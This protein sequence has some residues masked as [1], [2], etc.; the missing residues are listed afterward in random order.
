MEIFPQHLVSAKR[1]W[2]PTHCVTF[3]M[4]PIAL[5]VLQQHHYHHSCSRWLFLWL[6][7]PFLHK[8]DTHGMYVHTIKQPI[9]LSPTQDQTGRSHLLSY[10]MTTHTH[11][12]TTNTVSIGTFRTR[13]LGEFH[14]IL[15][16]STPID[17]F[18]N[19]NNNSHTYISSVLFRTND[20]ILIILFSTP[21]ALSIRVLKITNHYYW[22]NILLFIY[23]VQYDQSMV[24]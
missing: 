12:H 20:L 5:L 8:K 13:N 17:W 16:N 24:R 22:K 4:L 19:D 2:T 7:W 14:P 15:F 1:T 10:I 11:T 21:H 9:I 6:S 3:K 18:I 23:V